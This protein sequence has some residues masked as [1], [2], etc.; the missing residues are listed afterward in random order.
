MFHMVL[1]NTHFASFI[2]LSSRAFSKD[3][4]F[5]SLQEGGDGS[6]IS[7]SAIDLP[8]QKKESKRNFHLFCVIFGYYSTVLKY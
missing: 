3:K 8:L 7:G 1:V 2:G 4:K 5:V 6:V